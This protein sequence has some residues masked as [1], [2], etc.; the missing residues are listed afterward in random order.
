MPTSLA[1]IVLG[2]SAVLL[3]SLRQ[4]TRMDVTT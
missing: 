2:T 1:G 3:W 4:L